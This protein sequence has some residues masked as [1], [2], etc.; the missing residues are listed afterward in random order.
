MPL[1]STIKLEILTPR[2]FLS[3]IFLSFLYIA[4][5]IFIPNNKLFVYSL[6]N[7]PAATN[8][9]LFFSL[10]SGL[11]KSLSNLDFILLLITSLLVGL[12][13]ALLLKTIGRLKDGRVRLSVGGGSILALV[14]T[15]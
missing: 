9:K 13:L 14:A 3:S 4:L 8:F 15:G 11:P 2:F 1:W 12:N 6:Q 5:F 10:L 7:Y